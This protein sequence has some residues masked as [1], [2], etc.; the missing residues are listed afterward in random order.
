[1]LDLGDG[2]QEYIREVE[3]DAS[4][5]RFIAGTTSIIDPLNSEEF[6]RRY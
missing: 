1:M 5:G 2:P 3:Y 4:V 6:V